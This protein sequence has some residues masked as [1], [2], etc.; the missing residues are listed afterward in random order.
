MGG[1]NNKVLSPGKSPEAGAEGEHQG[2]Q[3]FGAIDRAI[4]VLPINFF[5]KNPILAA[6][7]G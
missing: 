1:C 5:L 3:L 7:A 2:H 4:N 6:T